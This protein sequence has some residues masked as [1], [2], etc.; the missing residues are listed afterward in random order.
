MSVSTRIAGENGEEVKAGETGELW[1]KGPGVMVGNVGEWFKTGDL[2]RRERF[3]LVRFVGRAKDVFKVS[4]YTVSPEDVEGWKMLGKSL[5]VLG[6][7]AEAANAYSKA[8][9][10][11]PFLVTTS[12]EYVLP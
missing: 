2:A 4:G 7:F 5:G 12:C 11:A 6:R 8:A 9:I 3:G 10:R 1:I